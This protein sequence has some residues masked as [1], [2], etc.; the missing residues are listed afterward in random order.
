VAPSLGSDDPP[1]A[2]PDPTRAAEIGP[3]SG[4]GRRRPR[5]ATLPSPPAPGV[6][7]VKAAALKVGTAIVLATGGVLVLAFAVLG[8]TL[9]P[10]TS[11]VGASLTAM[12]LQ[13]GTAC[14]AGGPVAG[15]D[16]TQAGM[17]AQ[18]VAAA[19]ATSGE[20][21]PVARIA[22][23]VA[24][25]ESSLRNLGPQTGNDGSLGLFQ[26]RVAAGWGTPA[27]EMDPAEATGMFVAHLLAV[28]GWRAMPPW[29]AAQMVQ[30][31]AFTGQPD[32]ANGGSRVFGGNYRAH[33]AASGAILTAVLTHG[34]QPG[35]CGQGVRGGVVG[36]AT[37]H[38]LPAG[39]AIPPGTGPAHAEAVQFALAQLGKPYVW[40]A[41]GPAAYDCSGLTMAAWA[42]AGVRLA[43]YTADQQHEG[44][45]V[46]AAQ[47]QAG[48]LVLTPGSDSPGPGLAGHVG[49]YLGYGLVESA[50][51]PQIGIVVQPWHTFVSGGLDALVDPDP[52]DA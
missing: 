30:G 11:R 36:P 43:H 26:Q 3:S 12:L 35:S 41:A 49:I 50:V 19:F 23:M 27:E 25:T 42:A 52:V 44:A 45:P 13:A 2:A 17:A 28:A 51:D 18:V 47:L 33:W 29:V 1:S 38:G 15:L 4:L 21:L 48:D 20:S 8:G 14:V 5:A 24:D 37:A 16:A 40:A 10:S 22:L 34:S 9:G 7:P 46:A 32:A 31:S 39:Y 6:D